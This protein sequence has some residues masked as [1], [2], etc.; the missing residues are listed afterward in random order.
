M[1][2]CCFRG[3]SLQVMRTNDICMA[4]VPRKP[5]VVILFM[6]ISIFILVCRHLFYADIPRT[7]MFV[8]AILASMQP[9]QPHFRFQSHDVFVR[10]MTDSFECWRVSIAF[11]FRLRKFQRTFW[12]TRL[13]T[14]IFRTTRIATCFARHWCCWFILRECID[15]FKPPFFPSIAFVHGLLNCVVISTWETTNIKSAVAMFMP[16]DGHVPHTPATDILPFICCWSNECNVMVL[17]L[18]RAPNK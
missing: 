8:S 2:W 6:Q 18:W 11:L 13:A 10:P 5:V 16:N 1:F 7:C 4:L 12:P 17:F 15:T 14:T 9:P 3:G